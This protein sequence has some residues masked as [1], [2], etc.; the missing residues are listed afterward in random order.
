MN[1]R[2]AMDALHGGKSV[3]RAGWPP[4]IHIALRPHAEFLADK[5]VKLVW[6]SGIT[7]EYTTPYVD[8]VASDW[9]ELPSK[10]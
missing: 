8:T 7:A 4:G 9:E 1:F 2:L 5:V 6:P 3:R 10:K